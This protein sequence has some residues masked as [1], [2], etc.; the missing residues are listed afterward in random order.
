LKHAQF[1]INQ[2]GDTGLG[3]KGVVGFKSLARTM[4][5]SAS[6]IENTLRFGPNMT[7]GAAMDALNTH[8][9]LAKVDQ[10]K[11]QISNYEMQL[12]LQSVVSLKNPTEANRMIADTMASFAQREKAISE[13]AAEFYGSPDAT[14]TSPAWQQ[15][16]N[17][18][19]A[20]FSPELEQRLLGHLGK[21]KEEFQASL[22]APGQGT[23]QGTALPRRADHVW[24]TERQAA[25]HPNGRGAGWYNRNGD[26]LTGSTTPRWSQE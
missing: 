7:A 10:T 24:V 3:A 11:G 1:L 23:G 8:M 4:G 22:A 17:A 14:F 16:L 9:A 15:R 21:T 25:A 26:F 20:A 19:P 12:F 13:A 5:F 18:I 6:A 2:A